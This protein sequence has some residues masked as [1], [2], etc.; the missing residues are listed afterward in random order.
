M[1]H[2][3]H[4]QKR[5]RPNRT[6][7]WAA[8]RTL[9]ATVAAMPEPTLITGDKW[10]HGGVEIIFANRAFGTLT[11]Y[12]SSELAGRN[13]RLLHGPRT[14][15]TILPRGKRATP[16]RTAAQ[17]EGWL[18]RKEDTPF[19]AA[20]SLSPAAA[21]AGRLLAVYH[22]ATERK[23]LQ[24]ALLHS[25]KLDTIGLLA[26]G[27]AHDFNNLLS[28][29]NGFSEILISRFAASAP[30]QKELRQIHRAG[31]K[32]AGLAQQILE[33]SRR[34]E[35]DTHAV[36]LNS[37]IREISEILRRVVGDAVVF[38]LRLASDLGNVR[39]DPTN[40]QQILLN[41]CFN[42]RDAM[43]KGGE[44]SI[45]TYN[46]IKKGRVTLQVTDTGHGMEA[47]TRRRIFEPF[48]TT[49][50]AGTGLGLAT[51]RDIVRQHGGRIVVH[52][53]PGRGTTFEISFPETAEAEQIPFAPLPPSLDTHGTETILL[54]EADAV[55]RGM[56]SGI[57]SADGYRVVEASDP[58]AALRLLKPSG[59]TPH[60]LIADLGSLALAEVARKLPA[61]VKLLSIA[62]EPPA[63]AGLS[64][65]VAGHLTKPFALNLLMRTVRSLLDRR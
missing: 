6:G 30:A 58:T 55:L 22:D 62:A 65:L 37:L 64:P 15:L 10:R 11:G 53:R 26:S 2:H 50:P 40:F 9:I 57:L 41:L 33:F 27:V 14:D 32:A 23:R 47:A 16:D 45:H 46:Q 59:N 61:D 48:F 18:Y 25:H 8:E 42:A 38:E 34:R 20:W 39:L 12:K 13:T 51:V 44:L 35:T 52:S 29:I 4:L 7:T 21:P 63:A 5:R 54:V 31:R 36:N 49:K 1:A 28:I 19:Y 24:E 56:I 60:L 43:P 3:P 17:G